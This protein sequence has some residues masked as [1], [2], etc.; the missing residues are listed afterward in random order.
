MASLSELAASLQTSPQAA[1]RQEDIAYQQYQL[2]SQAL[3]QAKQ[4]M[5]PPLAGMAGKV[6]P[7]GGK[8]QPLGAMAGNMLGPQYKLTTADG[9]LTSSGLINQTMITAQTEAEQAQQALKQANYLSAMGKTAESQQAQ[10]E[11]RRLQTKAQETLQN[12]QKQ[13]IEAKD[14]FASTL[15]GAK[16]QEDYERRLRDAL[17]RTGIEAPKDIPK[18]WTP[19]MKEKLLSKMS[20]A[21]RA[22]TEKQE[23][24]ESFRRL[25]EKN[26]ILNINKKLA[27]G[28]E[29]ERAKLTAQS[30]KPLVEA[31]QS[32]KLSNQILTKLDDPKVAESLNNSQFLRTLLETPKEM[33][34]IDKYVRT[35]FYEQLPKESQELVT[36]LANMRN[37][38]Y[39]QTSGLAVTGGEAARNFFS[40]VQ[41][42]DDVQT[43]KTKLAVMREKSAD[44]L[45]SGIEDYKMPAPRQKRL[46]SLISESKSF[47]EGKKPSDKEDPLGIR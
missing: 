1:M 43:I 31:E 26:L 45:S 4:E 3:Q 2:Q 39:K 16:S 32:L 34:P 30:E 17:E 18:T 12:A 29:D 9:E 35:G 23:S 37:S 7:A 25:Q 5:A 20:P 27:G 8:A 24:D 13:K 22:K 44:T 38:Y 41:P 19:D 40:V 15:Y 33:S 10:Q 47:D 6:A 11:A 42:S 21:M 14:D 36:L 46:Q 28:R